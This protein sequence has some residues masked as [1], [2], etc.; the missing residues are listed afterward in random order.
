[1]RKIIYL[2]LITIV[3]LQFS[4]AQTLTTKKFQGTTTI[5]YPSIDNFIKILEMR[6]SDFI[7]VFKD[8]GYNSGSP[9][10][11]ARTGYTL[12]SKGEVGMG[13]SNHVSKLGK[14][15]IL[16]EWYHRNNDIESIF[17]CLATLPAKMKI[18]LTDGTY[19]SIIF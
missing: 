16:F 11:T 8:N 4:S 1:M 6:T 10:T 13:G 14:S 15:K 18:F 19:K 7:S 5:I 12:M 2:I 9:Y 3:S 17:V